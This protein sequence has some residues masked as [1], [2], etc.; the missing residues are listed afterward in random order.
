MPAE[1]VDKEVSFKRIKLKPEGRQKAPS[2]KSWFQLILREPFAHF[3]VLGILIFVIGD[4]FKKHH[5][6]EQYVINVTNKDV[7]R[8]ASMWEKQYG[9][10]PANEQLQSLLDNYIREEILY[11]EGLEAGLGKDDEVIRRRIAQKQEFLFQDLA[12]IKEPIE[13]DLK[14]YYEKNKTKYAL[15]EK[16]SFSH[17]YFS[18]DIAGEDAAFARATNALKEL[19]GK[20]I[21]RAP[22]LGDRFAYLYDYANQSQEDI[23]HLFGSSVFTDSIFHFPVHKWHGPVHSGYGWHLV[24]V[25]GLSDLSYQ[26]YSSIK[27]KVKTDYLQ[28]ASDDKNNESYKKLESKYTIIRNYELFKNEK[29]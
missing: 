15:P 11:R 24:Y 16:L 1:V 2:K 7:Y 6:N 26:P 14:N 18:P 22:E 21:N 17:I 5:F 20:D 13:D 8:L 12:V 28:Q 4:Y 29:K 27:D 25:N 19:A 23:Y 10:I 3:V 9:A